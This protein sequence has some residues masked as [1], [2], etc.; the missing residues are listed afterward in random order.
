MNIDHPRSSAVA[1][2]GAAPEAVRRGPSPSG[3]RRVTVAGLTG[4]VTVAVLLR[5]PLL[6]VPLDPD[7]GGYAF[8]A[9]RWAEG[10][11]LYSPAAWVDRPPGLLV[12]FRVVGAVSY[13]PLGLRAA[14]VVAA[15]LV[16]LASASAAWAVAGRRAGMV[17]GLLS[18]VVLAGPFVEGFQLNGEL[19]AASVGAW[20]AALALWWRAGRLRSG[21]LVA[22]GLLC[23]CALL[24]KQSALDPLVLL[25][26]CTAAA[27]TRRTA[28]PLSVAG[29]AA[30]VVA[31]GAC[32]AVTD[33]SQWWYAIVEFQAQ[34][35]A[36][37][38]LW[39]RLRATTLTA[40]VVAP[41]MLGLAVVAGLGVAACRRRV[42]LWPVVLWAATA[43]LVVV[44]GPFAHRHYW[45]QVIPPFA[46]LAGVAAS[47]ATRRGAATLVAAAVA[48]PLIGQAA[49][50]ASPALRTAVTSTGH[51]AR[52]SGPVA[53]WLRTHSRPGDEVYA[54]VAAADLYLESDR[55]TSYPYLWAESVQRVPGAKELLAHWLASPAGPR[56]VVVYAPPAQV[57]P[58]GTLAQVLGTY[59]VHAASVAGYDILVRRPIH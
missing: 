27:T 10:G 59:Y 12:A 1:P 16:A 19:L 42:N 54:F 52:A 45:V 18:A 46:V 5:L 31:A 57:D 34:V 14:A 47:T 30:P 41:D 43:L 49:V 53:Q 24:V 40:L 37:V 36:A 15:V 17:A 35:A 11:R 32:A 23:G 4:I 21:W 9:R 33:W 20:G 38:P 22:A 6:R 25:L 39:T 3:R 29:A 56:Y 55:Q 51:R 2:G 48:L 44:S 28:V 50:A 26:A 7:E 8:I 13:S 58:G